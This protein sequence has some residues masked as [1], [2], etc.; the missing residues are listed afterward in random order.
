MEEV[1]EEGGKERDIVAGY[2]VDEETLLD[3]PLFG[4]VLRVRQ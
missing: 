3:S 1:I 4:N 2:D